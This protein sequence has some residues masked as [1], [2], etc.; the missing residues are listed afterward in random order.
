M[1]NQVTI[2]NNVTV[3]V[4]CPLI[5]L[6]Y[7]MTGEVS[8]A[9]LNHLAYRLGQ[10]NPMVVIKPKGG[11]ALGTLPLSSFIACPNAI[12]AEDVEALCQHSVL[13]S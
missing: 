1:N 4:T 12:V 3:F 13:L 8:V 7:A 9:T 6:E 5:L 11:V 2:T 10:V